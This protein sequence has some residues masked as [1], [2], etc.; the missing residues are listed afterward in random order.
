MTHLCKIRNKNRHR[1]NNSHENAT[2]QERINALICENKSLKFSC[3]YALIFNERIGNIRKDL[4][5][6]GKELTGYQEKIHKTF[7]LV[8]LSMLR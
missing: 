5:H 2:L 4:E 3:K 8:L 1:Q 6:G 7:K